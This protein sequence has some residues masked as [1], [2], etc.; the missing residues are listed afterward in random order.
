[1][2]AATI[3]TAEL[4]GR[5]SDPDLT[6][7][8]LRSTA[9]YNGWRPNGEPRGGHIP[10]AVSFPGEWLESVDAPEIAR[11]LL[12]KRITRDRSVVLYGDRPNDIDAFVA[13][14]EADGHTGIQ[15]YRDGFPHWA[16]DSTLPV[17]RLPNYERLVT[18]DWL[19][20][21]LA[22][23]RPEA[24][25]AGPYLLF[26]VNFGVPEEYADGHIPGALYLDT[27]WL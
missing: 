14:L 27:N 13:R 22:G 24:A 4:L 23:E 26:H 11:L 1:M 10:G 25:P 17:D 6:I 12:D 2:P 21:L 20:R 5:L 3:A 8:D 18:T 7:V 19:A 16:A 15:V 9:A